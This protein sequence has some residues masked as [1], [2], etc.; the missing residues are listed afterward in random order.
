MKSDESKL[1][2]LTFST[3]WHWFFEF[4]L[5]ILSNSINIQTP[6]QGTSIVDHLLSFS[7][8]KPSISTLFSIQLLFDLLSNV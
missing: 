6:L 5:F 8:D 2:F 1:L 7:L 3:L 4:L